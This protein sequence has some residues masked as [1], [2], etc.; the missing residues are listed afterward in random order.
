MQGHRAV[1]GYKMSVEDHIQ[2][3]LHQHNDL[4]LAQSS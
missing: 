2:G 1:T 4:Q 3:H